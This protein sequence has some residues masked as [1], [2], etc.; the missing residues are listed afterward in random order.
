MMKKTL[1]LSLCILLT[2]CEKKEEEPR[3]IRPV[4]ALQLV[5]EETIQS[6]VFPGRTRAVNRVNLSFRVDGPMI[7]R[8]VF[9]GDQ[10]IKGQLLARI[11]PRDY[12][13]NLQIVKGKLERAEAQLRFAERDYERAMNIWKKDPGAISKSLLDQKFETMNELKGQLISLQGDVKAAE[14]RLAYTRMESPFEGII[15]ATY[16]EPFEFVNAKQPI[17]RLLDTSKIEMVIDVPESQIAQ[18]KDIEKIIVFFD[19]YPG[20]EFNAS[21]R[22]IGT[23]A[24]ATT[25]TFPVTLL[26]DRPQDATLLAGMAGYARLYGRDTPEF[27]EQGYLLPTTAIISDVDKSVTYVWLIDNETMKVSL[28]PVE[29]GRLTERGVIIT[30]GLKAGRWVVTS[31]ANLLQEGQVVQILPVTLDEQGG[32]NEVAD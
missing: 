18:I 29:K 22:E 13:V 23:E 26:I 17:L 27:S 15:V 1:L 32:Q 11:D 14:D 21:I 7:E 31:G 9:V 20:R 19:S 3:S 4:R 8:P 12:E 2:S 5:E 10:V 16:V 6:R 24:S 30:G 25:R 28:Q